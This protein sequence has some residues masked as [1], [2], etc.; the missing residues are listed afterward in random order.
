MV[1]SMKNVMKNISYDIYL[2]F[3]GTLAFFS[4]I[5]KIDDYILLIYI[6]IAFLLVIAKKG[7]FYLKSVHLLILC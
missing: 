4:F 3:L 7:V 2:I 6:G 5:G 1:I